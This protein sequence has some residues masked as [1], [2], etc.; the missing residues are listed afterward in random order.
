MLRSI[1]SVVDRFVQNGRVVLTWDTGR[2]AYRRGLYPAYKAGVRKF[3]LVKSGD[4]EYDYMDLFNNQRELVDKI[5][6]RLGVNVVTLPRVEGDDVVSYCVADE[7][8]DWVIV[9]E[10]QDLYQLVSE[11]VSVYRPIANEFITLDVF[12][13][14][15]GFDPSIFPIYKAIL[16]D[17]SDNISGIEGVA[18]K[19]AKDVCV[20]LKSPSLVEAFLYVELSAKSARMRKLYDNFSTVVRNLS[21]VDLKNP[22]ILTLEEQSS[23]ALQVREVPPTSYVDA[24]DLISGY[25]LV[26]IVENW[27]SWLLPF[28]RIVNSR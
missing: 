21:L 8:T 18:H 20:V 11:R 25:E 17:G 13:T 27:S 19:T 7:D 14:N 3:D 12:K 22:E 26:S 2:S 6:S 15:Y 5:V 4:I 9:S 28:Q 1:R 16:G 23:I 24:L 10:D